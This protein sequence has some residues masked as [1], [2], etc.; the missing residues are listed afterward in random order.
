MY[1]W[2]IVVFERSYRAITACIVDEFTTLVVW[3]RTL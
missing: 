3:P 2:I 1:G